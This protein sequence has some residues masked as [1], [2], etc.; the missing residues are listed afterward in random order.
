MNLWH[1]ADPAQI[2]PESFLACIEIP[3]GSKNKY[4]LDKYSGALKL[5]RI[6]Y[7]STHYPHNYGFIPR[8]Y[9]DDGDPLDVL[10]ICSEPIVPLALVECYPIGML[11]MID[12]GSKDAKIIAIAKNDPVYNSFSDIKQIPNHIL[13]EIKHFFVVYKQLEGKE[14]IVN[15]IR[16]RMMAMDVISMCID[17]YDKKFGKEYNGK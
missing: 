15:N 8:T 10:V 16:G 14:T 7:T 4:E 1:R 13:Q 9:A 12:S 5:D 2:K 17:A 3:Q 6:L 11:E